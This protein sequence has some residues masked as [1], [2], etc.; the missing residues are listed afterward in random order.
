MRAVESYLRFVSYRTEGIVMRDSGDS[1]VPLLDDKLP[2]MDRA[3]SI[4]RG[5][6]IYEVQADLVE[7]VFSAVDS[8]SMR[9]FD[10]EDPDRWSRIWR[11]AA[12]R[13]PFPP[14]P[15]PAMWIGFSRPIE[16]GMIHKMEQARRLSRWGQNLIHEAN[17]RVNPEE[18]DAKMTGMLLAET[19]D[20]RGLSILIHEERL[21]A[22]RMSSLVPIASPEEGWLFPEGGRWVMALMLAR[23]A[24][25]AKIVVH[26]VTSG[27]RRV[28]SKSGVH[29]RV[30]P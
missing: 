19:D 4:A 9:S 18:L 2:I 22:N 17:F 6:Q 23:L 10:P 7:A 14:L 1:P 3:A 27:V 26:P 30:P 20:D 16:A 25:R 11:G 8:I 29:G 24:E 28:W 13:T 15:F 5:A 21:A 12:E